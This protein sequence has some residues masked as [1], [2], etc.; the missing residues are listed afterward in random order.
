MHSEKKNL[1][2]RAVREEDIPIICNFPQTAEEL[3]FMFPKATFPL[4]EDQLRKSIESRF[5][6]H[7]VVYENEVVAFANF[8]ERVDDA[9]CFI[10]NIIVDSSKRGLGIGRYLLDNMSELAIQKYNIKELRL[11]CF[12]INTNALLFYT[13]Y[14]FIPYELKPRVNYNGEKIVSIY[15]KYP[16]R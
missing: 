7:V 11:V 13:N 1:T 3:F 2:F 12:N 6:A 4:T 5:D 14:G 9:Y 16:I 15:M 8:Y 10:G